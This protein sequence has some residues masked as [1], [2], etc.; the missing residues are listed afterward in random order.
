MSRRQDQGMDSR[1]RREHPFGGY[2]S[3]YIKSLSFS[4]GKMNFSGN[5]PKVITT[6]KIVLNDQ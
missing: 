4:N 6:A 3:L 2:G 5:I 1:I